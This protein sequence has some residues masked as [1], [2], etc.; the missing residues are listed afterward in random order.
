MLGWLELVVVLA[1]WTAALALPCALWLRRQ[2]SLRALDE[3]R[4]DQMQAQI[5][6][7]QK[8]LHAQ[9]QAGAQPFQ[10]NQAPTTARRRADAPAPAEPSGGGSPYNQAIELARHGLSAGEVAER[11]GISRS[12]AELI[13][14]LYRNSPTA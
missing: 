14:S 5:S 12:E 11:C 4:F 8:D 7:L 2:R 3:H 10:V 9:A 1:L 6:R 13:V